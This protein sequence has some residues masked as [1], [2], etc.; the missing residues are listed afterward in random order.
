MVQPLVILPSS[1]PQGKHA[2]FG[3]VARGMGVVKKLGS[4]GTDGADRPL[5]NVKITSAYPLVD[6]PSLD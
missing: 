2:I 1:P 3:R 4:L 5:E 6:L